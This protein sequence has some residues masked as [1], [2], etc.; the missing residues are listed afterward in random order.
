MGGEKLQFTKC[1]SAGL[2]SLR[3]YLVQN[4]GV[5]S[6]RESENEILRE[7]CYPKDGQNKNPVLRDREG[8]ILKYF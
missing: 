2:I 3:F 1:P 7:L 6:V 4:S 8:T 5:A